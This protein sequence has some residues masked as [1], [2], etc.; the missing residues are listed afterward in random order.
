M[1][2]KTLVIIKPCGLQREILG[3]V[4]TRFERKGLRLAGLKMLRLTHEILDV[5]YAHL[6]DKP[7]FARIKESM[8][9]SPVV[10]MCLEGV[11]A[12]AV[13]RMMTG[14]TNGRNAASGTIRGDFSMSNQENIIHAS[15]SADNAILEIERFFGKNEIFDYQK[16]NSC[17]VNNSEELLI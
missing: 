3:E 9:A 10:L 15:D 2:E 13:V 7:F 4:I 8:M 16:I 12:V 1:L 17:F 6:V 11:E 5:H 14:V